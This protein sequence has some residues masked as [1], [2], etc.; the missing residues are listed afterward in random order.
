MVTLLPWIRKPMP[1]PM[2]NSTMEVMSAARSG[3]SLPRARG[4]RSVPSV[5]ARLNGN[6]AR[7]PPYCMSQ[8]KSLMCSGDVTGAE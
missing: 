7:L 6:A 8:V 1:P 5:T 4:A 3:R 2:P